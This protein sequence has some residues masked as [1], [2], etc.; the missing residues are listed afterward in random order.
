MQQ[1]PVST[2]S[3]TIVKQNI[4]ISLSVVSYIFFTFGLIS[5]LRSCAVITFSKA[6][7][8][9]LSFAAIALGMLY[10]FISRG[11]RRLER[12]WHACAAIVICFSLLFM[13]YRLCIYFPKADTSAT[14]SFFPLIIVVAVISLLQIWQ[15][16]VLMR[17]DIRVLFYGVSRD[18]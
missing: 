11:L 14:S 9:L 5:L 2:Q 10:L 13:I 4:P 15:L 8:G 12:I 7:F 6:D 3:S 1:Q 18:T 16:W 17:S